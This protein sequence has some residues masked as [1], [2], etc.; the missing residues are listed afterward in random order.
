MILS[1]IVFF[2]ILFGIIALCVGAG[3]W[4]DEHGGARRWHVWVLSVFFC[5]AAAAD[6]FI[7]AQPRNLQLIGL[8]AG[9]GALVGAIY[10]LFA[11]VPRPRQRHRESRTRQRS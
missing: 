4:L 3:M 6:I 7:A 5:A 2:G 11:K 9:F 1:W 8:G 10:G